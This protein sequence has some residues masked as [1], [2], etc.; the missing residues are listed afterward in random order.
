MCNVVI[1][2]RGLARSS[3]KACTVA[4]VGGVAFRV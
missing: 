4:A 1:E 2:T 3:L